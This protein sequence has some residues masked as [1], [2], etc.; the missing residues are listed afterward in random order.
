M[1]LAKI[2][3][4][5]LAALLTSAT[6][7]AQSGLRLPERAEPGLD[8][9]FARGWFAP[10][11]D[12]FGFATYQWRDA[13]GFAPSQRLRWS[14]ALGGRASFS[15]SYANGR[16]SDFEPRP[17]SLYG[18]YWLSSEWALSAESSSRD[19]SGIFRLQDFRI[20]LQRRF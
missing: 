15:M 14:Y 11:Y 19:A 9:G 5:C 12:R 16:E 17:L 10:D 1:R 13:L 4:L 6:V 8:P 3:T 20:G 18:R 2:A 7:H